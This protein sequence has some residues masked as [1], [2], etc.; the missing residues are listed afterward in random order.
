MDLLGSPG[1]SWLTWSL[2]LIRESV[3]TETGRR[4][5]VSVMGPVVDRLVHG[6]VLS[7][8]GWPLQQALLWGSPLQTDS[9]RFLQMAFSEF[10]WSAREDKP[11]W[12]SI[13]QTAAYVLFANVPLDTASHMPELQHPCV[14]ALLCYHT[15]YQSHTKTSGVASAYLCNYHCYSLVSDV[16]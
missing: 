4:R 6:G 8:D 2:Q 14:L 5:M 13:F 1:L 10:Q 3:V 15:E 12:A 7:W 11:Q 9:P 16:K